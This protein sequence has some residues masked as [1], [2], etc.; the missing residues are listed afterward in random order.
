M[1]NKFNHADENYI[2]T[3]VGG[4]GGYLVL[5]RNWEKLKHSSLHH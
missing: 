3:I 4:E 5:D 2:G 1:K